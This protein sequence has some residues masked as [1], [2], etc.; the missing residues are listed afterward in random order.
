MYSIVSHYSLFPDQRRPVHAWVHSG[1]VCLFS[2]DYI[3]CVYCPYWTSSTCG[4][5]FSN[6]GCMF[7]LICAMLTILTYVKVE[8][9]F[10]LWSTGKFT[11]PDNKSLWKFSATLWMQITNEVMNSVDNV[12]AKRWVKIF[13]LV[14]RYI[15]SHKPATS[16]DVACAQ[17]GLLSGRA[18]C[19]E[20]DSD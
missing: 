15:G 17:Q 10:K 16:K 13:E 3:L 12:T 14:E 6:C 9:A 2:Q 5:C 8:R 19:Y 20:A 7:Y 18:T 11:S 1:Y 4:P